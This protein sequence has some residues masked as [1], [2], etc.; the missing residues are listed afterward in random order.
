MVQ[1][2]FMPSYVIFDSKPFSLSVFYRCPYVERSLLGAWQEELK[3][4][5]EDLIDVYEMVLKHWYPEQSELQEAGRPGS[6]DGL[7]II[8]GDFA[9]SELGENDSRRESESGSFGHMNAFLFM[10]WFLLCCEGCMQEKHCSS[11]WQHDQ[12]LFVFLCKFS[13]VC[14]FDHCFSASPCAGAV[15][16]SSQINRMHKMKTWPG[17]V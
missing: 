1:R 4:L 16:T 2:S 12:F 5:R 7:L 8:F 9:G 3:T 13:S 10:F 6:K 14:E 11:K 15:G 17:P